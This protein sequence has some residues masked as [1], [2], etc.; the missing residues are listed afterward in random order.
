M[1]LERHF[2]SFEGERFNKYIRK[3]QFEKIEVD[4]YVVNVYLQLMAD[5]DKGVDIFEGNSFSRRQ[6]HSSLSANNGNK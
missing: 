1:F 4:S 6:R 5:I 2:C 3:C